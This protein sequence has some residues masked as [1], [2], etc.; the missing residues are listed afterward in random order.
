MIQ[1]IE[2]K[3]EIGA[4]T[5]GASL[6][7]DAMKV[8]ALNKKNKLFN[9]YKPVKINHYNHILL[10]GAGFNERLAAIYEILLNLSNEVENT[11]S[12][13]QIPVVLAGDHST[14]AG[15]IAGIKK[16]F[17]DKNIGVV[18]IDAHADLNSP[19]TSF[20]KNLHGMPLSIALHED[21]LSNKVGDIR[22]D[23]QEN[24]EKLKALLDRKKTWI[25]PDSLHFVGL[26][27]V[28]P[29]EQYL[30]DHFHIANTSVSMLRET[31]PAHTAKKILQTLDHCDKIYVSFD[32]DSL[33]CDLVSY[34]T[35]TPVPNGF[36]PEEMLIFIPALLQD[37]RVCCFEI[38]EINPTLDN[39][40]NKMAEVAFD[41]LEKAVETLHQR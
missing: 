20:S 6:G 32:V 5:R 28:E 12:K 16:A 21:N 24:W 22:P 31:G 37:S 25:N 27:D 2:V 14:A 11:L 1:F 4:G 41:V 34:G 33:D 9:N 17:P 30:I 39:K 3:S 18:W 7:V 36:K 29:Q 40:G 38:C 8:A 13:N 10:Y 15:T 19:Y 35:G 26:R 23:I